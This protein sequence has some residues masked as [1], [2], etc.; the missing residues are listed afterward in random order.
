VGPSAEVKQQ[1]RD[2]VAAFVHLLDT[3]KPLTSSDFLHGAPGSRAYAACLAGISAAVCSTQQRVEHGKWE[4]ADAAA[5]ELVLARVLPRLR[6]LQGTA[7]LLAVG[8]VADP[9]QQQQQQQQQLQQQETHEQAGLLAQEQGSQHSEQAGSGEG[10]R[11]T[12]DTTC[13][14]DPCRGKTVAPLSGGGVGQT[15]ARPAACPPADLALLLLMAAARS[16]KAG[17]NFHCFGSHCCKCNLWHSREPAG[18]GAGSGQGVE[19][20]GGGSSSSEGGELHSH[21]EQP[22]NSCEGCSMAG[23][24]DPSPGLVQFYIPGLKDLDQ[25]EEALDILLTL[26][27]CLVVRGAWWQQAVSRHPLLLVQVLMTVADVSPG[28]RHS[29]MSICMTLC[30]C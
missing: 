25:L 14:F 9:Q 3:V 15:D 12:S 20:E 7:H 6:D 27:H 29:I 22:S 11:H 19:G 26:V 8:G 28:H 4:G 13:A 23:Q 24:V 2:A 1:W 17:V 18:G 5:W 16:V 30:T 21:K 10:D